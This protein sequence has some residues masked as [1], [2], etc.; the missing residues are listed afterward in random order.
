MTKDAMNGD[1]K[2]EHLAE[3]LGRAAAEQLDVQATAQRVIERLRETPR[4]RA[5]RIQPRWLRVAAA[6]VVLVGGGVVV[7][8]MMSGNRS[9][10][11]G[12]A[13]HLVADDL[14]DLSADE[15]RDVLASFDEIIN[16]RSA[17]TPDSG[18]DLHQ[19]DAQQLREVLRSLEG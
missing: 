7:G 13:A 14:N 16:S 2:I 3:R 6:V 11:G 8:R 9:G 15:L 18:S 4:R 10:V 5:I 1:A 17:A 12:H 19:L